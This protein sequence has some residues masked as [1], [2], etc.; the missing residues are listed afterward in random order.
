MA[1][2]Y[3]R[4][5]H[6]AA[7]VLAAL[8]G[9]AGV[10]QA[11]DDLSARKEAIDQQYK[12]DRQACGALAGNAKD[13]CID[14][15]EGK[16]KVARAEL[17]VAR[18]PSPRHHQKLA[19]A[20]AEATYEVAKERCDDLGGNAKDVC[21]QDAKAAHTRALADAKA[22]RTTAK[23][24]AEATED[25]NE[26]QYKAAAERCDSLAGAAKDA[27]VNDAKSRYGQR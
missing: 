26:A 10:L 9:S 8:L 2:R 27:C 4:P 24:R 13:V 11:A 23:A 1:P 15:A 3:F 21:V 19:E 5:A 17:E 22:A 16:Q 7:A 6:I 14:E 18:D 20:R 25:K 12:T